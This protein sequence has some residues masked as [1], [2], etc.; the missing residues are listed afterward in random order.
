MMKIAIVS[1]L[2]LGYERFYEDAYRQAREALETASSMAD[3]IIIPG[4]IFD[5][6]AP[7]PEVIAQGINIFRDLKDALKS[8]ASVSEFK[9]TGDSKNYTDIPI[10]AIPGTHERTAIGR[11]NAVQL[12]SL[13]GL[14]VD[15][16]EATTIIAKGDEKVAIFGIGGISEERLRDRLKEL[17]P[18]PVTGAFNIFMMH[19]STYE[20]LPFS[21]DFIHNEELPKGFDLYV[22]GHIHSAVTSQVH[23]KKFLIPGSTVLTQ[24]KEG[25]QGKKG[26]ILF[27]TKTEKHEFI[28]IRTR[29]FIVKKINPDLSDS[30]SI[31]GQCEKEVEAVISKEKEKPIIRLIL[32]GKL[33]AG[34]SVSDLHLGSLQ[35]AYSEKAYLELDL[36]GLADESVEKEVENLR[37]EKIEEVP[38]SQLGLSLLLAKLKENGFEKSSIQPTELFSILGS[39]LQKEK[40]VRKAMELIFESGEAPAQQTLS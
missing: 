1:D 7:P 40:A 17:N 24:L 37:D 16:S 12:L 3:A 25:E 13:A 22:N 33:P 38:I 21:T 2:H 15:T 5:K 19:Q 4:D 36:S 29:P 20:L 11:E 10:I 9:S 34:V 14:L 31:L 6:R 28:G 8:A 30:S 23:G 35:R 26:F 39:D 32:K 18:R 27:D